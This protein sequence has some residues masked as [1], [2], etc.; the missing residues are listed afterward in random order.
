M[1]QI[2]EYYSINPNFQQFF[3]GGGLWHVSVL[4][5]TLI[6]KDTPHP[7]LKSLGMPL[8]K[9]LESWWGALLAPHSPLPHPSLIAIGSSALM[10]LVYRSSGNLINANCQSVPDGL[11]VRSLRNQSS[12]TTVRVWRCNRSLRNNNEQEAAFLWAR[13]CLSVSFLCIPCWLRDDLSEGSV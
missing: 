13:S 1:L 8:W 3:C 9:G 12:L 5:H 10:V 4:R 6:C 7:S 11:A 2:Y